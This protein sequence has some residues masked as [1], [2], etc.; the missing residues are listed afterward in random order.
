MKSLSFAFEAYRFM[1]KIANL[2]VDNDPNLMLD[3]LRDEVRFILTR[4]ACVNKKRHAHLVRL[5]CGQK[6]LLNREP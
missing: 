5:T 2:R 3:A 4:H 1:H 6:D